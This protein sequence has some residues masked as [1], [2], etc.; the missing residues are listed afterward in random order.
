MRLRVH[1]WYAST[2]AEAIPERAP[3]SGPPP[4]EKDFFP[5]VRKKSATAIVVIGTSAGGLDALNRLI[6][7][8]PADFPSAILIVQH[9]SADATAEVLAR[10]LSAKGNLPVSVPKDGQEIAVNDR[11]N[12]AKRTPTRKP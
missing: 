11:A 4:P 6:P 2:S 9:I 10:S 7:R 1:T 12:A 3:I 8:F 5:S